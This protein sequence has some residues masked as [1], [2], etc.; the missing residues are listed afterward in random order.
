[1]AKK[2]NEAVA[3]PP[4]AVTAM[5]TPSTGACASAPFADARGGIGGDALGSASLI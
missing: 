5:S 3:R 2:K 1:M 4:K